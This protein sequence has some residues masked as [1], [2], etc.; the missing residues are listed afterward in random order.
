MTVSWVPNRADVLSLLA[1]FGDRA[2]T[3]V[4]EQI[5]S[6]ELAWLVHQV[7]QHHGL[8]LNLSDEELL[9]MGTVSSAVEVLRTSCGC[10]APGG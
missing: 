7:E 6:L 9:R 10:G 3:D 4:P 5:G 1:S 8:T 2:A